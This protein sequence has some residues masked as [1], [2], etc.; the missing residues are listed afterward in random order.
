[1]KKA[2]AVAGLGAA[3][4]LG[5]LTGAG[6]ASA[7]TAEDNFVQAVG[8]N[9]GIY[10]VDG[11]YGI[12]QVGYSICSN[13]RSGWSTGSIASDIAFYGNNVSYTQAQNE[14]YYAAVYLCPSQTYKVL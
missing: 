11:Y 8:S 5:A 9:T 14:V 13:L 1:M 4:A 6:T 10:S 2:L 3:I 12:L 7:Y